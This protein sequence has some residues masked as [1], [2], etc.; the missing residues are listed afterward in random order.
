MQYREDLDPIYYCELVKVCP[1]FDGGDCK[2]TS[3]T[4]TPASGPQGKIYVVTNT[5]ETAVA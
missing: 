2:I 3:L 1:I 4:V 5:Y